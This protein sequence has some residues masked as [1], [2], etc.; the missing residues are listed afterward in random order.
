MVWKDG[1]RY[2]GE[3]KNSKEEGEGT[4]TYADGN[5]YIGKWKNGKMHGLGVF[6]NYDVKTK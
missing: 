4:F 3:F 5:K 1:R 2:V 6:L